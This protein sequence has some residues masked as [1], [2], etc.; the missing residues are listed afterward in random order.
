M[1]TL[2]QDLHYGLRMMVKS[3]GFTAVVV[4]TL[5]LGIGASTSIFSIADAVLLRP[6]PYR[7]PQQIVRVWELA[8]N[9][10]RMNLANWNFDDFRT[11]NDTFAS[12]ADYEYGLSSVSGGS[13]PV[14]VNIAVVSTGFFKNSRCRTFSRSR[15]F[16]RR[17]APTWHASGD[18]QLSLLAAIPRWRDECFQ[19]PPGYGRASL[20][21]CRSDAGRI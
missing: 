8:P 1:Q 2:W 17:A 13:E 18:R 14:R 10:R 15:I 6:L 7:N 19:I 16:S 4:L 21:R 9:G 12:L 20:S 5:A 3:P 11:Q